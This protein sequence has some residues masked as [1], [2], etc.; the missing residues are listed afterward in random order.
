[1]EAAAYHSLRDLQDRHW[2]FVGRRAIVARL[3]RTFARLPER[4][5]ILEAGCGYG[6]NLAMLAQFGD[7]DAFEL[8]DDARAYAS[9]R[10]PRQV[11]PGLLPDRIGFEGERFDLIAMLDVLEHVE[12]DHGALVALR[13]RLGVDGSILI[14]V[15]ALP[16]LWSAHD[17]IHHHHRRYT[18]AGLD[19][20]LRQAG[21]AP[22]SIGYF[23]GLLFPLAMAQRLA[24]RLTRA[25]GKPD[26]MPGPWLNRLLGGVFRLE[27][28]LVGRIGLPIGLSL[29]AVA[30]PARQ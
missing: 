3:I 8:D 18:R 28:H 24:A 17:A 30:R 22:A 9:L 23:N 15:P 27:R 20:L 21:Y 19:R 13:Q 6:G 11:A 2:W 5:R 25:A 29:Y 4:P 26:T 14:T 12:D 7:I 1:M 16:W 10:A